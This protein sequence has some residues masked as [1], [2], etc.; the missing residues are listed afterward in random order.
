M[1][2]RM[3]G[4]GDVMGRKLVGGKRALYSAT[5]RHFGWLGKFFHHPV[6]YLIV[7]CGHRWCVDLAHREFGGGACHTK[8]AFSSQFCK[9]NLWVF[10]NNG[11]ALCQSNSL[12]R[13]IFGHNVVVVSAMV[14]YSNKKIGVS[15]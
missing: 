6:Y 8:H 7:C 9:L 3:I 2:Q 14:N 4:F 13:V 5:G 15:L 1:G 12:F 10:A 11:Q